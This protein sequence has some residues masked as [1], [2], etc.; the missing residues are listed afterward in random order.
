[1]GVSRIGAVP[2]DPHT[3]AVESLL[4][5]VVEDADAV[6]SLRRASRHVVLPDREPTALRQMLHRRG[7]RYGHEEVEAAVFEVS[8]ELLPESW[9]AARERLRLRTEKPVSRLAEGAKKAPPTP[10][11]PSGPPPEDAIAS[12]LADDTACL[13][14]VASLSLHPLVGEELLRVSRR[15]WRA[16]RARGRHYR[17]RHF[18]DHLAAVV[19]D[20]FPHSPGARWSPEWEAAIAQAAV[21]HVR[22]QTPTGAQPV[23]SEASRIAFDRVREAALS[24]DRRA[25]RLAVRAWVDAELAPF[26]EDADAG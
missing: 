13:R 5:L 2:E 23:P 1:M 15:L 26:A 18:S 21:G 4:E 3:P 7:L 19:R 11:A 12:L 25:Y 6:A 10:D 22:S 8:L 9:A 17:G 14:E 20:L 16:L 24:E